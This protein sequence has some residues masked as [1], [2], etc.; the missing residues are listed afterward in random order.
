[1]A[2]GYGTGSYGFDIF[3]LGTTPSPWG[4]AGSPSTTPGPPEPL[5]GRYI[6]TWLASMPLEHR[7]STSSNISVLIDAIEDSDFD[8]GGPIK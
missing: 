1:M 8:I 5:P 3:E 7:R 4:T 6:R 2:G